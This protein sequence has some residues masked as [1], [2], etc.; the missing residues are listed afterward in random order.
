MWFS[1]QFPQKKIL[2]FTFR[3]N[4]LAS[5]KEQYRVHFPRFQCLQNRINE[6][7]ARIR[8]A[9]MIKKL[10]QRRR[11]FC[12][13]RLL[14]IHSIKCLVYKLPNPNEIEDVVRNGL[15]ETRIVNH[16]NEDRKS[17]KGKSNNS[18]KVRGDI[19]RGF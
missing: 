13:P 15:A 9:P 5:Q 17:H 6:E 19:L 16:D 1:V 4:L 7:R 3:F 2:Q 18:E 10:P 8:V 12:L 14:P 11:R